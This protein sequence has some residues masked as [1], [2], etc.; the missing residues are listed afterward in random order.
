MLKCDI[1]TGN[2]TLISN[3]PQS[4]DLSNLRGSSGLIAYE[5]G[6]LTVT[7]QITVFN[8]RRYYFHR[9]MYF[10]IEDSQYRVRKLSHPFYFLEK[11]V[12]FCSGITYTPSK[13]S[14]FLT[15]G[16]KDREAYL[17]EVDIK[18]IKTM[19]TLTTC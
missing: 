18:D 16:L 9:F 1:Q 19:L 11:D 12:E 2:I 3:T 5:D 10:E 15:I 6:Y 7:H 17:F 13:S 14:V 4:F 8:N